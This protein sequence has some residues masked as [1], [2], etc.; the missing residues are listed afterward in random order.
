MSFSSAY[1]QRALPRASAWSVVV[2]SE[3]LFPPGARVVHPSVLLA[4]LPPM[5]ASFSP[6]VSPLRL[7]SLFS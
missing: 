6:K 5:S 2:Y 3:Y 7:V 4:A 1:S